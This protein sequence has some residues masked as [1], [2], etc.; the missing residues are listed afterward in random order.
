M[1]ELLQTTNMLCYWKLPNSSS[2]FADLSAYKNLLKTYNYQTVPPLELLIPNNMEH[3]A[4]NQIKHILDRVRSLDDL[5][6]DDIAKLRCI[7]RWE[8]S[9][10]FLI[11][12]KLEISPILYLDW[13]YK[14]GDDGVEF[15]AQGKCIVLKEYP[16]WMH[17]AT[18]HL[19]GRLFINLEDR[20]S[21]VTGSYY[22][23]TG[24]T[25]KNITRCVPLRR[26]HE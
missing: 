3:E 25:S 11:I 9:Q 7:N 13:V 15:N 8:I 12:N 24:S 26:C 14:V 16:G 21:A 1:T 18:T 23:S 19:L 20:L 10:R 5:S 4:R 6:A 2:V 22:D 17:E